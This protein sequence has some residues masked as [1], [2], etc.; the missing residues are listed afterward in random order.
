MIIDWLMFSP[1]PALIGGC[2][3]GFAAFLL[4]MTNGKILG[5]S[6]ILAE[7]VFPAKNSV[8]VKGKKFWRWLF[9]AGTV[10]GPLLVLVVGGLPIEIK[11]IASGWMLPVAGLLVGFG[12]AFGNG[13]T[14][15]HGVCGLARLS[16][17]SLIAVM[18]FMASGI[19]VVYL[20]RHLL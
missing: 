1:V 7:V 4:M 8:G 2:T 13:C 11:P 14:S 10:L 18:T 6:G 5:A 15:G 17:R 12:A 9:L 16:F 19:A 3:I 20:T